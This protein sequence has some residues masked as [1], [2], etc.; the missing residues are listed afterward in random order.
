MLSNLFTRI[1]FA[2]SVRAMALVM[3]V[4]QA[5]SIPFIKERMPPSKAVRVF[6]FGAFREATQSKD[7]VLEGVLLRSRTNSR[8]KTLDLQSRIAG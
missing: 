8:S 3:F 5:V 4:L 7:V 2:W 6:D 1:G